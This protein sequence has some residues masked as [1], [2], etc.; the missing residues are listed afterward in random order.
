[1][2]VCDRCGKSRR[3]FPAQ[4]CRDFRVS[5]V[6][7]GSSTPTYHREIDLC[8]GCVKRLENELGHFVSGFVNPDTT[9]HQ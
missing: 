9:D 6:P 3:E 4:D 7:K 8:P 5:L 2:R 1:M